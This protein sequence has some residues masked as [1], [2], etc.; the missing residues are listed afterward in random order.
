MNELQHLKA[1]DTFLSYFD[2]KSLLTNV[3]L[4]EVINVC[5][6]TLSG[7]ENQILK[8][9]NFIL[10]MKLATEEVEFSFNNILYRQV[11]VITIQWDPHWHLCS[12]VTWNMRYF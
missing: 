10:L 5:A 7:L 12:W 8:R 11:D 3:P 4:N 9:N 2:L 1:N 6:D